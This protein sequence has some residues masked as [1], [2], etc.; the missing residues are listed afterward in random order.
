[1]QARKTLETLVIAG[2]TGT[3]GLAIAAHFELR[4][5]QVILLTRRIKPSIAFKQIV[6][7]GKTVDES[8]ASY[9]PGS[10]LVNLAGELVDRVP[11]RKNI[12]LL[13]SSRTEP[14]RGLALAA[15]RFGRPKLWLQS[16]TLAIYGDAGDV[17]LDESAAPAAGPRQMAG[18]ARAWESEVTLAAAHRVV[19]LRTAVVLQPDSPALDRLKAITKRFMGGTVGTGHQWVSWIHILDYLRALEFILDSEAIKGVVHLTS[20]NPVQNKDLMRALRKALNRPWTPP[21]PPVLIK[22]GAWLIFRTD[23]AL[24][25]TGRRA[26]PKKLLAHGFKFQFSEIGNA[27]AD[28]CALDVRPK[29]M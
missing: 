10:V 4:G 20:P 19:W 1:M 23:P 26:L 3:L 6:W 18:V 17:P 2:G 14:T 24:A 8:W 7:D 22:I 12:D 5:H 29:Q 16:S 11:T 27:L 21:T 25:L 9:L 15:E 28:L 13:E